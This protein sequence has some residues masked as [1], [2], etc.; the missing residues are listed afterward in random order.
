LKTV[1]LPEL[2]FPTRAIILVPVEV[3]PLSLILFS[4]S[5]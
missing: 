5:L 1:V 2:G 4:D 3:E